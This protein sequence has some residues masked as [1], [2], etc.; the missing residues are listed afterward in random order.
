MKMK[1]IDFF[2]SWMTGGGIFSILD[3][4]PWD[5]D[6]NISKI[7][8]DIEYFGNRSGHRESS[9]L[10]DKFTAPDNFNPL[11]SLDKERLKSIIISKYLA[12]WQRLWDLYKSEYEPL[13]NYNMVENGK[14]D[15]TDRSLDNYNGSSLEKYSEDSSYKHEN[16]NKHEET[17]SAST[18][19]SV[20]NRKTTDKTRQTDTK[21]YGLG[22]TTGENSSSV[23]EHETGE[24]DSNKDFTITQGN[25]DDNKS[26][27]DRT[28]TDNTEDSTKKDPEKNYT[29]RTDGHVNIHDG[30]STH[31]HDLTRRGNIGVTT[32]QQMAEQ[33]IKLWQWHYFDTVMNDIDLVLTCPYWRLY[34]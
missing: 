29:D 23:T 6:S 16:E 30:D 4:M 13:E 8:L 24:P 26:Y 15:I 18:Y 12:N 9:P 2:P 21:I 32:T 11:T 27:I 5:E 28:I 7:A 19:I 1:L 20:D 3:G 25:A 31:K 33:E 17:N 22:S 34:Q 14:D 10:L